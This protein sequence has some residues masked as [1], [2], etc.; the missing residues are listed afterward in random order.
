MI[1]GEEEEIEID[2]VYQSQKP[3]NSLAGQGT[4]RFEAVVDDESVKATSTQEFKI[5]PQ[6]PAKEQLQQAD[7]KQLK[8]NPESRENQEDQELKAELKDGAEFL[9]R[10]I[11]QVDTGD[12]ED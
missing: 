4:Q 6:E 3:E 2:K 5:L 9:D 12:E 1:D 7:E 8:E 10:L 11:D